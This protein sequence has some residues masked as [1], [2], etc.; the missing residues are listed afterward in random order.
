MADKTSGDGAE[1]L[2]EKRLRDPAFGIVAR[3]WISFL[4]PLL[5]CAAGL[6]ILYLGSIDCKDGWSKCLINTDKSYVAAGIGFVAAS[7]AL[8][9]WL[10]SFYQGFDRQRFDL[11]NNLHKEF[12]TTKHFNATFKAIDKAER[13]IVE[14]K[15]A[16]VAKQN[17]VINKEED[18]FEDVDGGEAVS[19]AAFFEIVAISVQS[20]LMS[21]DIANYFF[22]NYLIIALSSRQFKSKIGY[23]EEPYKLYWSLLRRFEEIMMAERDKMTVKRY[24]S[25]L[26]I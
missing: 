5:M 21:A 26:R 19:F 13:T 16:L 18:P 17:N 2:S 8:F 14:N 3:N 11:F 9:S 12:R 15:D 25:S 10:V 20:D 24:A 22:G 1:K 23:D 6:F 4:A 7:G